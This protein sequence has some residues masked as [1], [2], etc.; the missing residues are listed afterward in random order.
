MLRHSEEQ[1]DAASTVSRDA[2]DR[3]RELTD[4]GV[5]AD[6]NANMGGKTNFNASGQRVGPLVSPLK[7]VCSLIVVATLGI[8]VSL[9]KTADVAKSQFKMLGGLNTL[10]IFQ[11]T[12]SE[13][14]RERAY[15]AA[16]PNDATIQ[17]GGALRGNVSFKTLGTLDLAER[18][19]QLR[20]V[21]AKFPDH[22]EILAA[23]LRAESQGEVLVH[24]ADAMQFLE[25]R[26]APKTG[27]VAVKLK[28]SDAAAV[29]RFIDQCLVGERVDP[30]NAYFPLLR[31]MAYTELRQDKAAFAALKSASTKPV[32]REYIPEEFIANRTVNRGMYGKPGLI[33]EMAISA[34]ILFPHYA[35][36]RELSRVAAA[37][38]VRLE[39]QGRFAEGLSLR[40]DLFDVS[41][42]VRN[43]STTMIGSL[44]G[45]AMLDTSRMRPGGMLP[46]K[47]KQTRSDGPTAEEAKQVREINRQR[48]VDFVTKHGDA[49][50]AAR[51][52]AS[53]KVGDRIRETSQRGLD[54]GIYGMELIIRLTIAQGTSLILL[55]NLIW[56]L[57]LGAITAA[58]VRTTHFKS[59]NRLA[60]G[61]FVGAVAGIALAMVVSGGF[62]GMSVG[63]TFSAMSGM[64]GE[65]GSV[66]PIAALAGGLVLAFPTLL[67]IILAIGAAVNKRASFTRT[68]TG[69]FAV[70]AL[71][72]AAVMALLWTAAVY[73]CAGLETRGSAELVEML[74]HEGQYIFR[75]I[76]EKWPI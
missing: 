48:F 26:P 41:E 62:I 18:S 73:Y 68:I 11:G 25:N 28:V 53:A 20:R 57:I 16:H 37:E 12:D 74:Q 32:W 14:I 64:T 35:S 39:L 55:S 30:E 23:T 21:S 51:T 40:R 69:G 50:F 5:G 44:V 15:I 58:V 2:V 1:D 43:Q 47:S 9:P 52:V 36:M 72:L 31:A 33:P 38:A 75:I 42:K 27:T 6:L 49:A 65:S 76:G 46:Y 7:I 56:M 10:A 19:E 13:R 34:A 29:K 54:R 71:P 3:L 4:A 70:A 8:A 63:Y 60:P 24:R 67:T 22:P 17:F 45:G 66:L 61:P 59:G